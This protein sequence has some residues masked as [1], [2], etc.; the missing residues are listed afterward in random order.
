MGKKFSRSNACAIVTGA[1]SGIGYAI[2]KRLHDDGFKLAIVSRSAER[3][4]KAAGEIGQD[5][6][7]SAVDLSHKEKAFEA[8][9]SLAQ[10]MGKIRLL[11][12]NVGS[13]QSVSVDS[14]FAQAIE[15]W[16]AVL[17]ANLTSAFIV[18]L[19]A[20]PYI[21]SPGGRIIN[22][23]SIA[24]LAGSSRPGGL[25]YS[26]AKAGVL[27]FTRCLARE[28][29]SKGITVNAI[30][31]GLIANT[32]LFGGPLDPKR[33]REV[34]NETVLRRVGVPED[35]AGTVAWLASADASFVTGATISVNGGWHIA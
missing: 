31:P 34:V 6:L 8:I 12:N 19:A 2:A 14:P 30:A 18:S 16:D 11:V 28:L 1:S 29:G 3:I 32:D 10:K 22:I 24:G 13:I 27:G 5:V 33:Q 17:I 9:Q 21:E 20:L 15:N 35:I 4:E 25:A 7:W 26:A 23:S